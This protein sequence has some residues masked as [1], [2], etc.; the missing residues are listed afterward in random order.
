MEQKDV[1]PEFC[2][3]LLVLGNKLLINPMDDVH[4]AFYHLLVFKNFLFQ[5]FH[6]GFETSFPLGDLDIFDLQLPI[7]DQQLL[8]MH[9]QLP[10]IWINDIHKRVLLGWTGRRHCNFKAENNP[11]TEIARNKNMTKT[12]YTNLVTLGVYIGENYTSKRSHRRKPGW[13]RVPRCP[14]TRAARTGVRPRPL[15]VRSTQAPFPARFRLVIF[16]I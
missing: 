4:L 12:R 1:L 10:H 6:P 2:S 16:H 11:L 15:C 5:C 8:R 9:L 13:K 14:H 7:L 3:L